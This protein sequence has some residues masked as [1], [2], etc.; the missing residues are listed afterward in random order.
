MSLNWIGS[1]SQYHSE[2]YHVWSHGVDSADGDLWSCDITVDGNETMIASDLASAEDAQ[3]ACEE[4]YLASPART[5]LEIAVVQ[6]LA[7]QYDNL[8]KLDALGIEAEEIMLN[9]NYERCP[10]CESW[11][12]SWEL[13]DDDGEPTE[14]CE[15]CR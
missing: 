13:L 12:E 7:G 2:P 11:V 1:G 9:Y 10:E 5:Q 14:A 6:I 4:H 15:S 3:R 8:E